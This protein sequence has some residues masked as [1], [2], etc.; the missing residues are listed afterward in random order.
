MIII[1]KVIRAR[2]PP[3]HWSRAPI[4][5]LAVQERDTLKQPARYKILIKI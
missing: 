1:N 3:T 2:E 5:N 4:P